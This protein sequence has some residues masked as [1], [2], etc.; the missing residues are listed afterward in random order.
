MV[1]VYSSVGLS[2]PSPAEA[3]A[4]LGVHRPYLEHD[5]RVS[6]AASAIP[7]AIGMARRYVVGMPLP[8]S[9]LAV[10][11]RACAL[12]RVAGQNQSALRPGIRADFS[13]DDDDVAVAVSAMTRIPVSKLGVDERGRYAH[14]VEAIHAR[15][16]DQEE[17][18]LAVSRAVK[19]RARRPQRFQAPDRVVSVPWANGR[20]QDRAGQSPRR[21]YVRR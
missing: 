11:H 6:I 9:A 12:L 10:L 20:R 5:Y 17:A 13:L 3:A 19:N 14:M 2:K 18:V 1:V 8:A 4:I 21:L 7:A 16:V 15:I